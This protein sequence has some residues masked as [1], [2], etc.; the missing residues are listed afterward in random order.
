MKNRIPPPP[1]G[2]P[3]LKPILTISWILSETQGYL[4]IEDKDEYKCCITITEYTNEGVTYYIVVQAH[5]VL[6]LY[7]VKAVEYKE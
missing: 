3:S 2:K 5:R 6:K 4:Y 1:E 7:D